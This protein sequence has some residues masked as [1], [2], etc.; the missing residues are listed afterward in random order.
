MIKGIQKNL[1]NMSKSVNLDLSFIE[2]KKLNTLIITSLMLFVITSCDNT[3]NNTESNKVDTLSTEHI[4]I[5]DTASIFIDSLKIIDFITKYSIDKVYSVSLDSFYVKRK[6]EFAWIN[7]AGL[8]EYGRNFINLLKHE[9]KNNKNFSPLYKNQLDIF[10]EVLAENYIEINSNDTLVYEF[11]LLL[12]VNFFNYAKIKWGSISTEEVKKVSWFIERKKIDYK[13]LLE[14]FL[15]NKVD[16]LSEYEPIYH[17]YGRLKKYLQKYYD[18]ELNNS[19]P[20]WSNNI[21]KLEKG[22]SSE[23]I[24][25]LKQ[26]LYLLEDLV[27]NDSTMLFDDQLEYAVQQ[28]QKRNGLIEDGIVGGKTL[29]RFEA[30]IHELIQQIL[31]NMER[32]KWVPEELKGNY[33]M[34]NIPGFKLLVYQNDT[35]AWKSNVVVGKTAAANHT[36]IFNNDL[37]FIVFSPYWNIPKGILIKEVLPKIKED[38]NYLANNNMEIVNKK[39]QVIPVSSIEWDKFT[40]SLPYNIRQKPGKNNA[41]GLVKFLFPNSYSIYMHD[42]PAKSL[43]EEPS[44]T[45][46]H[47]CIRL[48]EPFKLAKFLLKDDT[49]YTEERITSLM[50]LGTPTYVKLKKKVPVFITYFTAWV[51]GN[52]KLNL[53]EDVYHHDEKMK[54]LL[55]KE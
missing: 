34:V 33:L 14:L 52:G 9:E 39:E 51:D 8:N 32:C 53:R 41:L 40:T 31:I 13:N 48:Q 50:N 25:G 44:R 23:A 47:G 12:T 54:T 46:S 22:D 30:S 15:K 1:F 3:G 18:I 26:Q 37:E 19:W 10:Y 2:L 20:N 7:N 35:I 36:V 11:E 6:N 49:T 42:T 4:I 17:Q 24:I 28:F 29:K 27:H 16:E 21:N 55:F 45:F 38:P 43:L 5:H